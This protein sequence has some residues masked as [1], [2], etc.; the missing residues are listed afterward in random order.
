MRVVVITGAGGTFSAGGD[1]KTMPARLAEPR[2]VR[3]ANLVTLAQLVP[4]LRR[5]PSR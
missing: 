2:D 3:A 5:C 4:R 1:L